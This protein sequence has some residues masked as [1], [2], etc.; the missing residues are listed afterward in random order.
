MHIQKELIQ[1]TSE[2][3]EDTIDQLKLLAASKKYKA[4]LHKISNQKIDT[5][6]GRIDI[7][8]EPLWTQSP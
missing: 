7:E 5:E 1:A 8:T 2:Y 3:F 4:I 6:E